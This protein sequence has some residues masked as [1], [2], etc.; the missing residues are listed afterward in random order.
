MYTYATEPATLNTDLTA[1]QVHH[2]MKSPTLLARRLGDITRAGFIADRLLK[3]RFAIEGGAIAY[4]SGED[5]LYPND[6]AEI[7]GMG[8]EYPLTQMDPGQLA[9]AKSAKT[10][11]AALVF[12][13]EIKRT[14]IRAIEEGLIKIRNAIIKRVDGTSLGV[15]ASKVTSTHAAS[16]PW[17]G[18]TEAANVRGLVTTVAAAKAAMHNLEIGLDPDVI[19]LT[20]VQFGLAMAELL[21]GGY[22]PRE[23]SGGPLETGVWPQALGLTWMTSQHTPFGDPVLLDTSLL[24]GVADEDLQSPDYA[25]APEPSQNIEVHTERLKGGRDGYLAQGRRVCVPVVTEPRAGLRIA[26]T[27]L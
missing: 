2:L 9:I 3:G 1:I 19:V 13:E 25:R 15:I 10:G 14:R 11:L 8:S 12:D 18:G 20:E 27:G 23:S 16:A 24:G 22:L 17:V 21:I 26:G 7:V 4:P 5:G 6:D